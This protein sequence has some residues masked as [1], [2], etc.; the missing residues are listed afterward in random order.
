MGSEDEL[1]LSCLAASTL[2]DGPHCW[3]KARLSSSAGLETVLSW[4]DWRRAKGS[5]KGN[6]KLLPGIQHGIQQPRP[7]QEKS[8]ALIPGEPHPMLH[9]FP[10]PPLRVREEAQIQRERQAKTS[11]QQCLYPK[12]SVSPKTQEEAPLYCAL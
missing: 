1:R 3:P 9:P 5:E 11:R 2:P 12:S 10:P 4:L 7:G 6:G 8:R